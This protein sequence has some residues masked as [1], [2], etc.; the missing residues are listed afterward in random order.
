MNRLQ[1]EGWCRWSLGALLLACL[2]G[3]GF[4]SASDRG[5]G[6]FERTVGP[7]LARMHRHPD[8]DPRDPPRYEVSSERSRLCD[9]FCRAPHA[10]RALESSSDAQRSERLDVQLR[11]GYRRLGENLAAK[12]WDDPAGRRI[13]FD[14]DG[15][16]GLGLEIPFD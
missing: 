4:A 1:D 12:L 15:R 8:A 16:P 11:A 6:N 5:N 13:R 14:I 2:C 7:E 10:K 3:T 9:E